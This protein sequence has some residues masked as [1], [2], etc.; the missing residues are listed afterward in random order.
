MH[1]HWG[2]H[3]AEMGFAIP[4]TINRLTGFTPAFSNRGKELPSP[5][6]NGLRRFSR[7]S[8]CSLFNYAVELKY[9]VSGALHDARENIDVTGIKQAAQYEKNHGNLECNVG[10]FGAE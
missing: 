2:E 1:R 9:R 4:T 5:L 3:I 6:E 10:D 7:E 8:S